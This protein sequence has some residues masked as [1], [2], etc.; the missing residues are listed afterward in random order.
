VRVFFTGSSTVRCALT[1][2]SNE[3]HRSESAIG[4]T[5]WWRRLSAACGARHR[6]RLHHHTYMIHTKNDSDRTTRSLE[7]INRQQ[8]LSGCARNMPFECISMLQ[9][10]VVQRKMR[11]RLRDRMLLVLTY[12]S[13]TTS[14]IANNR[15]R[16]DHLARERKPP[17][18]E[19][20]IR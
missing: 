10:V 8:T 15:F 11:A 1:Y 9:S 13:R 16:R 14:R 18:H 12:S 7:F 19:T 2:R 4:G 20:M 5:N 17:Q 6:I 3:T